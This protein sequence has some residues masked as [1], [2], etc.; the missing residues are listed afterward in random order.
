MAH[1]KIKQKEILSKRPKI[2][3]KNHYNQLKDN[4]K[5]RNK[6]KLQDL[7]PFLL[8]Q[9]NLKDKNKTFPWTNN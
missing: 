4:F 6:E 2:A 1:L 5:V 3:H 8:L 9:R 7:H